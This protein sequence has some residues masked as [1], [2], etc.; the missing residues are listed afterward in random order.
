MPNIKRL[1][2]YFHMDYHEEQKERLKENYDIVFH[3]VSFDYQDD[4]KILDNVSF[5][6]QYGKTYGIIGETG[7]GKSTVA[8]LMLGIWK[9][10]QGNVLVG[11]IEAGEMEAGELDNVMAYFPA[12]PIIIHDTVYS[13]LTMGAENVSISEVMTVLEKMRLRETIKADTEAVN[14]MIGTGGCTLSAGEKQRIG[15]GR[16]FFSKKRIVIMDE[17]TA[18]LDDVTKVCVIK[19][20]LKHN[21][22]VLNIIISHDMDILSE[23]NE[24][25]CL[26]NG[27]FRSLSRE[28][29]EW[30]R[31]KA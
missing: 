4:R 25:I 22:D 6:F 9:P 24:V 19:E 23:C 28:N 20:L 30:K 11:G 2:P 21:K 16:M 27:K 31:E 5:R 17:P 29:G 14:L 12:N 8:K 7:V 18:F 1:N 15:L 10:K 13:N 3:N 26:E